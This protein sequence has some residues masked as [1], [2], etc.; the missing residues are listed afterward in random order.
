MVFS[1]SS[2]L[3]RECPR[4]HNPLRDSPTKRRTSCYLDAS[5]PS[6]AFSPNHSSSFSHTFPTCSSSQNSKTLTSVF[7][8]DGVRSHKD[9]LS[10]QAPSWLFQN[11]DRAYT[12]GV[13]RPCWATLIFSIFAFH[14]GRPSPRY[15][16]WFEHS[17]VTPSEMASKHWFS[18][19]LHGARLNGWQRPF[20]YLLF[21]F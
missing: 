12:F 20:N 4:C 7:I 16:I 17:G 3:D 15:E 6:F 18:S 2:R 14:F 1:I 11:F 19:C 9:S 10:F 13:G 8:T 5:F 21:K